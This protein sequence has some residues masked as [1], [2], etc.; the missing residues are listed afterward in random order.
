M[1]LDVPHPLI[2][3]EE[4]STTIGWS[5]SIYGTQSQLIDGV[6][7]MVSY[8][9]AIALSYLKAFDLKSFSHLT[10]KEW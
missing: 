1:T 10:G 9:S 8:T 5:K 6:F 4:R 7:I 3:T 2:S